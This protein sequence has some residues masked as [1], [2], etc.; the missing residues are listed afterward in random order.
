[1]PFQ[2]SLTIFASHS[3]L[4]AI[5]VDATTVDTVVTKLEAIHDIYAGVS[6]YSNGLLTYTGSVDVNAAVDVT[7]FAE[8]GAGV[9]AVSLS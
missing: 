5:K 1:M 9:A 4:A 8:V 6:A 3:P 7:A 2:Q